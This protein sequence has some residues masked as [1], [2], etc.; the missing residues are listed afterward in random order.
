[1]V[2]WW[3]INCSLIGYKP[4]QVLPHGSYLCNI[5]S[6]DDELYEKACNSMLQECQRVEKLGLCYL[7][8]HPGSTAKKCTK[9]ES[10]IV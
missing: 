3:C 10:I 8:V 7:N 5:G 9:E 1:M 2:R 6:S 4:E